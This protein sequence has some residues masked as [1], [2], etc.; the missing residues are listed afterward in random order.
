MELDGVVNRKTDP[1]ASFKNSEQDVPTIE[2]NESEAPS[3]SQNNIGGSIENVAT[4]SSRIETVTESLT[5]PEPQDYWTQIDDPVGKDDVKNKMKMESVE[6]FEMCEKHSTFSPWHEYKF[7]P[8]PGK[9]NPEKE[10]KNDP[11]G[12]GVV[13][14]TTT[15][16]ETETKSDPVGDCDDKVET[17]TEITTINSSSELSMLSAST[18]QCLECYDDQLDGTEV[19]KR[20]IHPP[21]VVPL[22]VLPT[23]LWI[24]SSV[25][26][27]TTR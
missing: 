5:L 4:S 6:M 2:S 8:G 26:C 7:D 19:S 14:M 12:N 3:E 9:I 10:T 24:L 25:R 20:D 23:W 11:D 1:K 21:T 22:L 16:M 13:D 17:P 15:K 18:R 27:S